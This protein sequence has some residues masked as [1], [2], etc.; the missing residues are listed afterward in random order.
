[1][2]SKEVRFSQHEHHSIFQLRP[3]IDTAVVNG[4]QSVWAKWC[5][6][7]NVA[8]T[9]KDA[10]MRKNVMTCQL[11]TEEEINIIRE[12]AELNKK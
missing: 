7:N 8:M 9:T 11:K 6:S 10:V 1:M 5:H 2:K 12:P 3:V 4:N